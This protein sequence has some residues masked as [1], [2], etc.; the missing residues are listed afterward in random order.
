MADANMAGL[1]NLNT[2][3]GTYYNFI[4]TYV[5]TLQKKNATQDVLNQ[6]LTILEL[7]PANFANMTV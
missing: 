3:L 1:V 7:F 6:Y 2:L 5:D 4:L